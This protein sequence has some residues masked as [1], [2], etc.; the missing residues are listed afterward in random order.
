MTEIYSDGSCL[1]NPGGPGGWAFC[2]NINSTLFI[3]SGSDKCTTNNRMELQAVIECLKFV[4]DKSIIIHT[5]SRYVINCATRKF[6]I[7]ANKDLWNEYDAASRGKEIKWVWVKGHSNNYYNDLV[8]RYAYD[9]AK[10]ISKLKERK[11]NKINNL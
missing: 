4:N 7:N 1:K 2:V 6:K 5:D 10:N 8:D 9:E 11:K 3:V